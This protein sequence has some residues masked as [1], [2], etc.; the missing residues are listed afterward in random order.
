M[1]KLITFASFI[2]L[3]A[4]AACVKSK[5]VV[6]P[7]EEFTWSV[8]NG[9][10][11]TADTITLE[12][13]FSVNIISVSKGS[14]KLFISTNGLN[15]GTYS[16]AN[17]AA[18]SGITVGGVSYTGVSTTVTISDKTNI[19]IGGSFSADVTDTAGHHL[20]LSGSFKNIL[21]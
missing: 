9:V 2:F 17:A 19:R 8:N 18:G 5:D 13:F 1:K 7:P 16:S 6:N 3:L 20:Q 15:T 10:I 4:L 14:T 21:Y 12:E 11:Q